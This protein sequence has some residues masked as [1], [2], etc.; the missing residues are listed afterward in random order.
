[1]PRKAVW[2]RF[3]PPSAPA[4][5]HNTP[6][7][8]HDYN[9]IEIHAND[10]PDE[11]FA[12]Q[13]PP[14]VM[15]LDYIHGKADEKGQKLAAVYWMPEEGTERAWPPWLRVSLFLLPLCGLLI[16][17]VALRRRRAR[18]GQSLN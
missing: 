1:M 5:L 17:L 7:F 11:L 12:L 9:V 4:N 8:A 16:L 15:V 6:L 10:V 3:P 14:G 13:I 2:E 18:Q